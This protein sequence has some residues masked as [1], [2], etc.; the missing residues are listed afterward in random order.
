MVFDVFLKQVN[1]IPI[2]Q[3]YALLLLILKLLPETKSHH[4]Q[5]CWIISCSANHS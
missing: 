3:P 2:L 5:Q 1:V 4:G